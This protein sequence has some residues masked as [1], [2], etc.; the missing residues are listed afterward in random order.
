M[1]KIIKRLLGLSAYAISIVLTILI[2]YLSLLSLKEL[3]LKISISDKLLHV[4]AYLV[5]TLSWLFAILKSHKSFKVKFQV[6]FALFI[7]GIVIE[8]LQSNMPL[9][10]H[11]DYLDVFAN[12]L[13]I[14]G[15]I[16]T[17]NYLFRFY[18]VI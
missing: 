18:K 4:L 8:I 7:F 11:G 17:F 9:N 12:F 10:R 1:R 3:N 5:L 14:L 16:I 15:G 2:A 13:G 6:G